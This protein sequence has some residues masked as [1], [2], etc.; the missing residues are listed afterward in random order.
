MELW[1]NPVFR[2]EAAALML[3]HGVRFAWVGGQ[4]R[5]KAKAVGFFRGINQPGFGN[6]R[7]RHD[8][9]AYRAME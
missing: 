6:I 7:A 3:L 4:W 5:I 1:R 9:A 2:Q 8:I